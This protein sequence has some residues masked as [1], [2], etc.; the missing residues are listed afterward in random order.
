MT[1]ARLQRYA[2][3]LSGFNYKVEFKKGSENTNVDCFSRAPINQ[4]PHTDRVINEEVHLLCEE[5]LLRVSTQNL[6][7]ESI[8]EETRKDQHLSKILQE[9]REDSTTESEFTIDND[10]IFRG[11]RVVIPVIL[12]AFV[13]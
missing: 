1:S 6:A 5:S 11:Q 12:Q 13:L 4:K 7:F 2:T 3:F 9:L 8:R 10:I